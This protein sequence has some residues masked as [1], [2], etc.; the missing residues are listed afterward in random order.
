MTV[1]AGCNITG[2]QSRTL[3]V[4][5]AIKTQPV[6]PDG[7]RI[8]WCTIQRV[9]HR[10]SRSRFPDGWQNPSALHPFSASAGTCYFKSNSVFVK[11]YRLK[12]GW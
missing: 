2:R 6:V 5:L 1:T 12:L 4:S 8:V 10:I 7:G 3:L 9:L 11:G